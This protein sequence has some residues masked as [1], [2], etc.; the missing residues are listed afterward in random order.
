MKRHT[1][2]WKPLIP[3]LFVAAGFLLSQTA[4]KAQDNNAITVYQYRHVPSD[5]ID[6]F[7]KRETT[8][9]T[10]VAEK[11]VQNKTMSFWALFEKV[12]GYD[13]PNSSNFLFI[14]TFPDIDR[15]GEVFANADKTAGV[16]MEQMETESMSTTTSMFFLNG[17]GWAQVNNAN[18]PQDFNY[19]VMVYHDTG[20]PD[21]LINLENKYWQPFVTDAMNNKKTSLKAWGNAAVLSPSGPDIKFTTVS[22]DIYKTLK[23][24]LMPHWDA[25]L[26]FPQEGLTQIGNLERGPRASVVYRVVKV[27]SA[28]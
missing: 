20:N 23:D 22:Y 10:K 11:A 24:A 19:V 17:R 14:N 28:N 18:P 21:S 26:T 6:E 4:A 2:K 27:V 25:S 16:K 8:Y 7:I 5:K 12:G 1:T 9:W 3:F 13:L 15:V